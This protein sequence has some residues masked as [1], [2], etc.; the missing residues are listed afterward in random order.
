MNPLTLH[1]T[2]L[3]LYGD[4]PETQIHYEELLFI[5]DRAKKQRKA[6]LKELDVKE[7]DW[8]FSE[9]MIGMTL[10]VDLFAKDLKNLAK[11]VKYFL[12]LGITF[13]HL[14]PL[15]KPREGE[16]DGGYAVEDFRR[17]DPALGTMDDLIE[18]LDTFRKFNISV[19]IDYVVNH[20]AKEHVWAQAAL[21]HDVEAQK[22]FIMFDTDEIPNLYNQ[23]VPE[24]L[25]DKC[26][27]NF[28]YVPEIGKYVFT[29]FSD[30]QWDLNFQNPK[31]LNGMID[32]LLYLANIGVNMIR[33]DAIP[34][35][36]K[37]VGTT[38]RNLAPIHDLM[39]IFHLVKEDVCPSLALLG[40][41]IVE[42]EQIVSY[43]GSD[44][45]LECEVMYNANM[46]VDIFN[47][48]ATRDVRL[49]GVDLNRFSIPK[50]ATWMNYVRCHDDI[51]WGFNEEAIA[52]FGFNPFDHKQFLIRF[53]GGDFPK[54]FS[55]GEHYQFNPAT[56]DARTNGTLAS[57]LGLSKAIQNKEEYKEFEA[58]RRIVL[59]HAFIFTHRGFP[60][61]YSGDEIATLNDQSYKTDQAKAAEGRWVHRPFFDWKRSLRR[62]KMGTVEYQV[63]AKIK[64]LI[65]VRKQYP[66]FDGRTPQFSL[67]VGNNAVLCV[68]RKRKDQMLFAC[69]NFSEHHQ[70]I[71]SY[72]LRQL[73]SE[74]HFVD[75]IQGRTFD[76]TQ[77]TL[78][79]SP[80]EF[81]WMVS[82][83]AK[84]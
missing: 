62:K 8:Y 61:I 19:C 67:D 84:R 53:Y 59:A 17:V 77:S 71:E 14:M 26:P 5:M 13:I 24:V 50:R 6:E 25:P 55:D 82:K 49:M 54:S 2:Y 3:K 44:E 47:S 15:L 79:L 30:F 18:V 34:F 21:N 72:R 73:S 33:L 12:E 70:S 52:Q 41:A 69:F 65:E 40:E 80:Y 75:L 64:Q 36:W 60:L 83:K 58:I 20:V 76:L 28:T 57:L 32:N 29:S 39:R 22:M 48:F 31:V 11:R 23:T 63:F 56:L 68:V 45:A 7:K 74:R 9:Q 81:V 10:Y 1:E 51:G 16:N 35:L 43:F 37:E 46:M 66:L 27:G 4:T 38:C 42:P 78:D